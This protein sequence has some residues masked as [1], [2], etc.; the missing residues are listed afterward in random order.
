MKDDL[1]KILNFK[2]KHI[3]ENIEELQELN[4]KIDDENARLRYIQKA[5][6]NFKGEDKGFDIYKFSNIDRET[7]NQLLM[8]LSD[9]VLTKFGT[10]TCNYDGLIYL[11]NG[12]NNGVSL[13]LT[14]EQIKA[15]NLFI[16]KL[17]EKE[18]EYQDSIATLNSDKQNLEVKD[19]EVLKNME[20]QYSV[21]I[22]NIEDKRYVT[23][24]DEVLRAIEYSELPKDK[25]FDILSFLLR[26]NSEVYEN[27]KN[28]VPEE[29]EEES[30]VIDLTKPFVLPEDA[31][32]TMEEEPKEVVVHFEEDVVNQEEVKKEAEVKEVVTPKID[33]SFDKTM[34]LPA[35]DYLNER[36]DPM[37]ENVVTILPSEDKSVENKEEV[38]IDLEE[39]FI[40]DDNFNDLSSDDF[41]DYEPALPSD[42][43]D[44][45]NDSLNINVAPNLEYTEF[46]LG[47]IFP[48]GEV[49]TAND[50]VKFEETESLQEEN[51]VVE[52]TLI[53]DSDLE[54]LFKEY[55]I[56]YAEIDD[57]TKTL[58][59][60]GNLDS[61]K[62]ILAKLKENDLLDVFK[63]N[64]EVLMQIVLYSS[65]EIIEKIVNII[66]TSLSVDESDK[67]TTVKIMFKSMPSVFVKTEQGNYDNFIKNVQTFKE[68]G[69]DLINL[70]DFS[71]EIYLVNNEFIVN[72]YKVVRDYDLTVN[73]NNAKYLLML[74]NINE[75]ID[76]LVESVYKDNSKEG[77]GNTF[78]GMEYVRLYPNKLNIINDETIKRLRYSSE[79]S[80]KV[81]G[82]KEKS[83]TGEITNLK[84]DVINM[85][86]DYVRKF[87]NNEFDIIGRDEVA[88]YEEMVKVS[89]YINIS[90]DELLSKLENNRSGMRY[91]IAGVNISRNKVIRNYNILIKN[92]VEKTKALLFALCNNLVV[93]KEEYEKIKT[94]VNGLGGN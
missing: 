28:E 27:R 63:N 41:E 90:M 33:L 19:L 72:N 16:D 14:Q 55:N 69:I 30:N 88:K 59:Q 65:D 35:F 80:R 20:N 47:E 75:K 5:I 58:L 84:V 23:E 91:V 86:D 6:D 48:D 17:L 66:E 21:I 45:S 49:K 46:D 67:K 50:E 34:E 93:T 78:D 62:N 31:T 8:E 42:N 2:L 76:L 13:N 7:F 37:L 32:L 29:L 4:A 77:N 94:F 39:P 57:V 43:L 87:F 1:I 54:T 82:T 68:Y 70:F 10:N 38:S 26:Y 64:Q 92:N 36:K 40:E 81:F 22:D 15:I 61:Y 89:E 11:I 60:K 73:A 18:K 85:P 56:K 51:P 9:E 53:N 24:I 74:K 12:I 3:T 52:N 44:L 71:K 83:L 25:I 79:N